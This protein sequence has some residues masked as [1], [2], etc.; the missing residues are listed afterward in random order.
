MRRRGSTARPTICARSSIARTRSASAS[1][2]TSSTTTSGRTAIT[3]PSS[4]PTTS[5]TGTRTT[6]DARS[7]SKDRRPARALLRR[8]RGLLDRR[9]PLRRPAARRDAGHQGRVA[10]AR[11][12]AIVAPRAR[13]GRQRAIYLVAENEPQDTRL[14]RPPAD[15]RL[16]PRRAVERRL[17]PHRGRRADRPARGLLHG[18]HGLGAGARS[19]ARSTAT[20]TR[21]SGTRGRRSGAARRR[22]ICRRTRSSPTSRITIRSRTRRSGSGCTSCRRRAGIA[23]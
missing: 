12:R 20:S 13:G 4:R 10:R 18:L 23:R 15:G 14:V 2:S 21:G 17:P 11:A 7:T 1:S 6:G 5:P 8:E 3:W 19:P 16:R 22:S 9:V